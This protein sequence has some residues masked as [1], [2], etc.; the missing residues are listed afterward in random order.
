MLFDKIK[1]NKSKIIIINL[2]VLILLIMIIDFSSML[3]VDF[4]TL[5]NRFRKVKVDNKEKSDLPNYKNFPWARK[6][7]EELVKIETDFKS[8]YGWRRKEFHGETI[9][10]DS[11]GIRKTTNSSHKNLPKIVFLGGSTIWG[12]GSNNEGTIPSLFS[13]TLKKN[14]KLL[15]MVNLHIQHINLIFF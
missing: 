3:I 13:Q 6:N 7:L 1:S 2:L 12:T 5:T 4:V 10:I 8:F 15:T 9:D 11:L 14:M